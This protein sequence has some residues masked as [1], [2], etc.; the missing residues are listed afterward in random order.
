MPHLLLFYFLFALNAMLYNCLNNNPIFTGK[1]L[2]CFFNVWITLKIEWEILQKFPFLHTKNNIDETF[3]TF[4]FFFFYHGFSVNPLQLK[5]LILKWYIK[6]SS[7]FRKI[8]N[9][10]AILLKYCS[11]QSLEYNFSFV[12]L[13]YSLKFMTINLW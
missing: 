11:S 7:I 3:P 8:K 12:D 2:W 13:K 1:T 6:S 4:F 9:N 5:I 10:L